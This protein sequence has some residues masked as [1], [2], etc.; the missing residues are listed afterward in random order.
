MFAPLVALAI[1]FTG[2]ALAAPFSFNMTGAGVAKRDYENAR[3]THYNPEG[4]FGG[5]YGACGG[6]NLDSQFVVALNA[7]VSDLYL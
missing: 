7:V 5:A 3:F 6:Q 1:T 4:N 2:S